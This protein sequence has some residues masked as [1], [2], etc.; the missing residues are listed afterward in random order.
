MNE[1][2]EQMQW[3]VQLCKNLQALFTCTGGDAK[4]LVIKG[5]TASQQHG[6]V[7]ISGSY[8]DTLDS[9]TSTGIYNYT[10]N[11]VRKGPDMK[12][13]RFNHA[14][15]TLPNGD[16][17]VFGGFNRNTNPTELSLCEVFNVKS[18]SF[19]EIGNMTETRNRPAAV[20][21]PSG[22]VLIIGGYG[23]K[24]L[25]SCE[26]YNPTDK[27]FSASKATMSVARAGHTASLLPDGKVLVCGGND[28]NDCLQT[29]E[30][31]DPTTDSFSVGPLMTVKRSS[32]TA[33]T[34]VDG[35]ILLTGGE[36][37]YASEIYDPKTNC[38]SSGPELIVKRFC[39]FS[40]L[41]PDGRVFIGGGYDNKSKHTTEI[42][43]PETNSFTRGRATLL[44]S[45]RDAA[46]AS[47]F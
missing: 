18:N 11:S 17:A 43:D 22:L 21:L 14:S 3:E 38:F 41:L 47:P 46:S 28:E 12:V 42:Y 34:L 10:N 6:L 4:G 7:L 27:T 23:F 15:V 35:R 33:T 25:N 29:T 5:A 9:S 13:G 37:H 8:T 30:I 36:G 20:L 2:E 32:H 1:Q 31:Y 44:I 24:S 26:F 45:R 19:A 39:H 16:V 40:A